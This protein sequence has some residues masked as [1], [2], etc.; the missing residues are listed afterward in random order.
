[1]NTNR[2]SGA[3]RKFT[4][5]LKLAAGRISGDRRLQIEGAMD[6]FAGGAQEALGRLQDPLTGDLRT[7]RTAPPGGLQS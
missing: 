6:R 7:R 2:S 1:M 5:R 3:A 4:G